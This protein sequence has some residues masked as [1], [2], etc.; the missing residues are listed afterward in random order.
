MQTIFFIFHGYAILIF[1]IEEVKW[2]KLP[3]LAED[4]IFY[5]SQ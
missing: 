1:L 3:L 4:N 2:S 5:G